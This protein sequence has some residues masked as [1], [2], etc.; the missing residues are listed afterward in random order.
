MFQ[1]SKINTHTHIQSTS[2]YMVS[3]PMTKKI[4]IYNGEKISL[5]INGV[6]KTG[7]QVAN[8]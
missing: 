7:Q 8:D 4:R 6:E 2:F 3:E 1:M 5:S